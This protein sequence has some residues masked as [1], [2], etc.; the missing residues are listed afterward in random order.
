MMTMMQMTM[1]MMPAKKKKNNKFINTKLHEVFS[2]KLKLNWVEPTK[3]LILKEM[4][5]SEYQIRLGPVGLDLVRAIINM[6]LLP[7]QMLTV[8]R[9]SIGKCVSAEGFR[10][11]ACCHIIYVLEA[12][13]V[14]TST[15]ESYTNLPDPPKPN[16][17][18][19]RLPGP[20]ITKPAG[21]YINKT[22]PAGARSL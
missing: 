13:V 20:N 5:L 4:T 15:F 14:C 11:V 16:L 2:V 7:L 21:V 8:G 10:L 18:C 19:G 1:L 12:L 17:D 3:K 9:K 22:F 6:L